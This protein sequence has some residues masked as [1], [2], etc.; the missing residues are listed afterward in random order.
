MVSTHYESI[1]VFVNINCKPSINT[2]LDY[3]IHLMTKL[4]LSFDILRYF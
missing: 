3:Y 1:F 2:I 4:C